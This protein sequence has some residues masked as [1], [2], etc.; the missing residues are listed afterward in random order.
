MFA[1]GGIGMSVP[2]QPGRQF[3]PSSGFGQ[4]LAAQVNATGYGQAPV[5][6]QPQSS[7]YPAQY[8]NSYQTGYP[9]QQQPQIQ[10]NTGYPVQQQQQQQYNTGLQSGYGQ[11]Q[12]Q[13]QPPGYQDVAQFDPYGPVAQGWG[14]TQ[15]PNQ[16]QSQTSSSVN[17]STTYN[18]HLH[19]REFIRTHKAE[20]EIWDPYA[21]KQALNAFSALK[22]AWAA[23]KRDVEGRITQVQRD[24]GYTG[25]QEVA[26]LQAVLQEADSNFG[27]WTK[28]DITQ[29]SPISCDCTRLRGCFFIPNARGISR[30]PAIK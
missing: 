1:N 3:Q 15:A 18:G 7:G 8:P 21:W 28:S 10:Y 2:P 5:Q 9:A 27:K 26:R 14:D 30:I 25:Q 29:L 23:R 4:Q 12:L 22:D 20:L 19:P 13:P 11:Q 24:Y 16:N 6:I 17:S